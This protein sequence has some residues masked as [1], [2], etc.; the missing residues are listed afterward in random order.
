MLIDESK[1][2]TAKYLIDELAFMSCVLNDLKR[3]ILDC[4][5]TEEYQ[6][7]AN[8]NGMKQ[9]A[10]LQA[11]NST[12]KTYNTMFKQFIELFDK[13]QQKAVTADDEFAQ[14]MVKSKSIKK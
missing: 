8:Q 9:S 2:G 11:Y 1:Q 6:N 3:D 12:A 4:G 5:L 7:G 10:S 13:A 14:F